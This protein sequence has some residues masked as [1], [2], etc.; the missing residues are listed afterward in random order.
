MIVSGTDVIDADG[1]VIASFSTNAAAWDFVDRQTG[2][3][4][5]PKQHLAGEGGGFS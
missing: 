1:T 2:E 3:D 4:R 5:S